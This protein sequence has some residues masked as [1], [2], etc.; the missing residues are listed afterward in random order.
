MYRAKNGNC[1]PRDVIDD[2]PKENLFRL[3]NI[4][5]FSFIYFDIIN[6]SNR[7]SATHG[8]KLDFETLPIFSYCL[9]LHVKHYNMNE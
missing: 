5:V 7:L 4:I 3:N 6:V 1:S 2:R 8:Q 9:R